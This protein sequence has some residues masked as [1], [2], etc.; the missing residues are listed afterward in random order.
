VKIEMRDIMTGLTRRRSNLFLLFL[1]ASLL[2]FFLALAHAL[3]RKEMDRS[4]TSFNRSIVKRYELTD[5][6]LFT[7]A[8]Y[9]R[10]PSQTDLYSAFQDHPVALEHFPAGSMAGI[11]PQVRR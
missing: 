11:P 7:E 5:L 10:H 9:A 2:C 6:C 8:R 1:A 4:F 3:V